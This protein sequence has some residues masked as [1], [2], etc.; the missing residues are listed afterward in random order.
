MQVLICECEIGRIPEGAGGETAEV[1]CE[2][3]KQTKMIAEQGKEIF[4]KPVISVITP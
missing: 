1:L 4:G 3:T 2:S